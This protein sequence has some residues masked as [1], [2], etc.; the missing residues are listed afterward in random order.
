MR[1]HSLHL[2]SHNLGVR[3]FG[4][5]EFL[6]VWECCCPSLCL[7]SVRHAPALDQNYSSHDCVVF[8]V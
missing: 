1:Q 7:S 4:G 2:E 8:T 6:G 3:E 5:K